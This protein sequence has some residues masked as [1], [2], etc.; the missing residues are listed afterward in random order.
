MSVSMHTY[1]HILVL[2]IGT[3]SFRTGPDDQ[4]DGVHS[5]F[6]YPSLNE[7]KRN[8][9][10]S[11]V[12]GPNNSNVVTGSVFGNLYEEKITVMVSPPD[13]DQ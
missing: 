10:Q 2:Q 12:T 3:E 8:V 13:Q 6:T 11:N 5:N 4:S 1:L 7:L 9:R